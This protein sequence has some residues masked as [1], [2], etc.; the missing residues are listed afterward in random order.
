MDNP[1]NISDEKLLTLIN[2]YKKWLQG[3]NPEAKK[4]QEN[5]LKQEEIL[6]RI[7][8]IEELKSLEDKEYYKLFK[9]YLKTLYGVFII[10]EKLLFGQ[11]DKIISNIEFII[12][13]DG[14][15]FDLTTKIVKS[16]G[17]RN[18][19]VLGLAFWGP[20]F[21]RKF[22]EMLPPNYNSKTERCLTML[23]VGA[24]KKIKFNDGYKEVSD[25][26]RYI[27][28][29]D[30]TLDFNDIDHLMHYCTAVPEGIE[31]FND[32]S[33]KY[34]PLYKFIEEHIDEYLELRYNN[35]E[36]WDEEYKWDIYY[37][38][39]KE[40]F[41]KEID[42]NNI[43]EV[44]DWF[45]TN[46]SN[47]VI[48]YRNF[49]DLKE[50]TSKN[51]E[52]VA[53]ALNDLLYEDENIEKRVD[54]FIDTVNEVREDSFISPNLVGYILA[55]YDSNQYSYYKDS[56]RNKITEVIGLGKDLNV[57]SSA[58]EKIDFLSE[59]SNLTGEH[60]KAKEYLSEQTVNHIKIDKELTA[61]N[62]H[63]FLYC[64]LCKNEKEEIGAKG[65]G[66]IDEWI[67][68]AGENGDQWNNFKK[69]G[70]I[71]ISFDDYELGDLNQ[72]SSREEIREAIAEF[73]GVEDISTQYKKIDSL[74]LWNFFNTMKEGD[75]VIAKTGQTQ[76]LGLGT[77]ASD[78]IY[79]ESRLSYKYRRKVIWEKIGN[80]TITDTEKYGNLNVSTL[81]HVTQYKGY[82]DKLV[83][84]INQVNHPYSIEEALNSLYISRED[85]ENIISALEYKKNVILQGPPGVGKT[86]FAKRIAYSLIGYKK[87]NNIETVQFHQSYSYED[88][89]QGFRPTEDGNFKLKDGLFYEFCKKATLNPDEK[90]VFIIDEINRGN[91]SKIFGELMMLIENDKRGEKYKISLA[92]GNN[93]GEK[94]YLPK[95]LY[96]IGTMNTADR[97]LAMVDYALRRRFRFIDLKPEFNGK[98]SEFL[99]SK[100]VSDE[101]IQ[102]ILTKIVNINE[103]ISK[104]SNLGK[105][106]T[107]G[108]SY[109]TPIAEVE[110]SEDWYKTIID[111]E[112]AP[113]LHEYYF[114]DED[115][116]ESL[117]AELY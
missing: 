51:P 100:G 113:L 27:H 95:N 11:K 78:Y 94:F 59:M 75:R 60:L 12:N 20:I 108:H 15:P 117:I 58:G 99:T 64:T 14:D 52:I 66:E 72:Y 71:S 57:R 50:A 18:I 6:D 26:F 30:E 103:E 93:N 115:K 89:I 23:G 32:I 90:F 102:K 16:K 29:L 42:E 19:K 47:L 49:S 106:F 92:Y 7:F 77:I 36:D 114:D 1:F 91:L 39:Q 80:W 116:A 69:D 38:A 54:N 79:D 43:E 88:F 112:I 25:A 37:R 63:D 9:D 17:E 53:N 70:V 28:S 34:E 107:I 24:D 76:I 62:G 105:G 85:F 40:V 73:E 21:H 98:F 4:Y 3:D 22:P 65:D 81:T 109:F 97:S 33:G 86:F 10:G 35:I 111:N 74:A 13:F 87:E 67:I 2:S 48:F 96:L 101:I 5:I 41:D 84:L 46:K 68:S 83:S 31:I 110:D 56:I 104:E 45:D 55:C 44:I 82:F 61:I 8:T